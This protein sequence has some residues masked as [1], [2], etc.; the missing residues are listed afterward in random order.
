MFFFTKVSL[1]LVG[2][3][4]ASAS[5]FVV[6]L[7]TAEL[8]PTSI[9]NQAVGTCSLVA[10][11]GGISALLLDLLKTYWLPAPVFI[12][13][14]VATVAGCLAV[15]F[16]ETLGNKLPESMEEALRFVWF[17]FLHQTVCH[18]FYRIGE[19]GGRGLCSCT[20]LSLHEMFHEDLKTVPTEMAEVD[21]KTCLTVE[22]S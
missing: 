6:Y 15:F 14:L 13:G 19:V 18:C 11:F 1:S 3:F 4:G 9:R 8:F 20:C 17:I 2:K 5:F 7:Y 16:P 21:E 10:R 12:M 22:N